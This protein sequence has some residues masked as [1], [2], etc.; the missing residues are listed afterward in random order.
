MFRF[1]SSVIDHWT[2]FPSIAECYIHEICQLIML[3]PGAHPAEVAAKGR[4]STGGPQ[5]MSDTYVFTPASI[6]THRTGDLNAS[7]RY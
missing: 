1:V 5:S 4:I 3:L 6:S 2:L 7:S